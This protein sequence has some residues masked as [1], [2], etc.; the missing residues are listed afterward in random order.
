MFFIQRLQTFFLIFVT[1]FNVFFIFFFWNVFFLHLWTRLYLRP[2]VKHYVACRV[3][4]AA[5]M[6]ILLDTKPQRRSASKQSDRQRK[7]RITKRFLFLL[8]Y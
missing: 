1:F 4:L 6:A 5:G 3:H 8:L 7:F 2:D